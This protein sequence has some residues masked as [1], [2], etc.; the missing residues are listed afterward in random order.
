MPFHSAVGSSGGTVEV[1]YKPGN[2]QN[3]AVETSEPMTIS[4]GWISATVNMYTASHLIV[5]KTVQIL[6]IDC[7]GCEF[8]A[9]PEM[10]KLLLDKKRVITLQGECHLSLL[11]PNEQ[12]YAAKPSNKMAAKTKDILTKRGCQIAWRINC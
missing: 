10:E 11:N 2:S 12:T 5:K 1:K 8:A 3:A 7:E 9:V 4:E 6:K